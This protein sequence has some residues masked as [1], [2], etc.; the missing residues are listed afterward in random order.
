MAEPAIPSISIDVKAKQETFE[1]ARQDMTR[2]F[3]HLI[4]SGIDVYTL[5]GEIAYTMNAMHDALQ[6]EGL[7]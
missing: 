7:E 2:L 6:L 1:W 5:R 3:F 4:Q